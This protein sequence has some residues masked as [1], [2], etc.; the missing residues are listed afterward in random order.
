MRII[1][2]L[3]HLFDKALRMFLNPRA[4]WCFP[5]AVHTPCIWVDVFSKC[6]KVKQLCYD[7]GNYESLRLPEL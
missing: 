4:V 7:F 3:N 5:Y 1:L 2:G 6:S